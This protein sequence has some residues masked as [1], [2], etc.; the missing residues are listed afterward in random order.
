MKGFQDHWPGGVG[1]RLAGHGRITGRLY[2]LGDY[3]GAVSTSDTREHVKGELYRL[4]D[5][6]LAI[7][8]LDQYEEFFPSHPDKSLF[9]RRLV[10][11]TMEDGRQKKAWA[12][13]YNREVDQAD[14]IPGG[15]YRDRISA[16]K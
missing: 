1:A 10:P 16:R 15:N 11:V 5:P 8:I 12:Y 14:W 6:D 4:D 3:P 9:V 2:D 7:N 13:F